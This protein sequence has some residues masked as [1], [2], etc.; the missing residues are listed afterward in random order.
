MLDDVIHS[1][2]VQLTPKEKQAFYDRYI[3]TLKLGIDSD[4]RLRLMIDSR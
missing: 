3:K 4:G 2:W 1:T